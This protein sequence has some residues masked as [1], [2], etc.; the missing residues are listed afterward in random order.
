MDK[1]IMTSEW[2]QR[3]AMCQQRMDSRAWSRTTLF[4]P[5]SSDVTARAAVCLRAGTS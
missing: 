2:L 4:S 1:S 5:A 3:K